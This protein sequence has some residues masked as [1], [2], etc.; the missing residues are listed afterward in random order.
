MLQSGS[1]SNGVPNSPKLDIIFWS[2]SCEFFS[3]TCMYQAI[4]SIISSDGVYQREHTQSK[5]ISQWNNSET[6]IT[7]LSSFRQ[8]FYSKFKYFSP[9]VTL[10]THLAFFLH[11]SSFHNILYVC[12]T[13]AN[14]TYNQFSQSATKRWNKSCISVME[15]LGLKIGFHGS[16]TL[17][18]SSQNAAQY[19]SHS[20]ILENWVF[21]FHVP[22]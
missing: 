16:E 20:L 22:V 8:Y 11:Y 14:S 5:G 1:S 10:Y 6:I 7:L 15:V 3:K 2:N 9:H 19:H 21:L 18:Q 13:S 4:I 17:F 12:W